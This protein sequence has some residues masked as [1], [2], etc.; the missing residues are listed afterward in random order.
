[1]LFRALSSRPPIFAVTL[2][3]F[4]VA[5]PIPVGSRRLERT[6]CL[7]SERLLPVCR[8]VEEFDGSVE[9]RG[10]YTIVK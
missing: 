4:R 7:T 3:F 1:M 6:T 2:D 10:R 9:F 5:I 8:V